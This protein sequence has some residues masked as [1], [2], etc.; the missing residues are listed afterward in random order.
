MKQLLE[1][2]A[3]INE[4]KQY[5]NRTFESHI[6]VDGGIKNGVTGEKALQLLSLVLDVLS[7]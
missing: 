4:V 6:I 7:K 1:S 5:G 3:R 2:I